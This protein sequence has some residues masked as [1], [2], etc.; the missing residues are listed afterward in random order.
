MTKA[1]RAASLALLTTGV[2]GH[3]QYFYLDCKSSSGFCLRLSFLLIPPTLVV[4]VSPL[5]L[6]TLSPVQMSPSISTHAYI[7]PYLTI[8]LRH[9]TATK[10]TA[11]PNMDIFW[12]PFSSTYHLSNLLLLLLCTSAPISMTGN[13][14]L[15]M[16]LDISSSSI[17]SFAILCLLNQFPILS[18][19]S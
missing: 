12:A 2:G 19:T 9:P 14:S 6:S 5:S 7:L 3:S 11:W 15:G 13:Y 4:S 16:I 18:S 17:T 1:K 10:T 8:L